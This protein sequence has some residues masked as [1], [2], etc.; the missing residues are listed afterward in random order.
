MQ[1]MLLEQ[2]AISESEAQKKISYHLLSG[3][4]DNQSIH[5]LFACRFLP[6]S[7]SVISAVGSIKAPKALV[8][9]VQVE[10]ANYKELSSLDVQARQN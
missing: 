9:V 1:I 4:S 5:S 6:S 8:F 2:L 3:V 10:P 7:A